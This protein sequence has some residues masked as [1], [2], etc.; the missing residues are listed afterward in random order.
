MIL[1][2]DS[3]KFLTCFLKVTNNTKIFQIIQCTNILLSF[4]QELPLPNHKARVL[5]GRV[6]NRKEILLQV[7][8]MRKTRKIRKEALVKC[9][10]EITRTL[11]TKT[12]LR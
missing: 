5:L 6:S 9:G 7:K 4:L 2:M 3:N 10:K 8:L 1:F 12:V 11:L